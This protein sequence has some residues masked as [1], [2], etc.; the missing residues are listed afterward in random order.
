MDMKRF[1]L[2]FITIAALALA[3]C[4][5]NGG[6]GGIVGNG[7]GGTPLTCPGD[8]I[9]NPAMDM[10]VD[11][12]PVAARVANPLPDPDTAAPAVAKPNT[13]DNATAMFDGDLERN[14]PNAVDFDGG[15][16]PLVV[17][18][19]KVS[20]RTTAM[21]EFAMSTGTPPAELEGFGGSIHTRTIDA[22]DADAD[23]AV[24]ASD[25]MVDAVTV[26]TDQMAAT[27][28]PF[29]TI[30]PL[31]RDD[32]DAEAMGE[33]A[34]ELML[35]GKPRA[36]AALVR[37]TVGSLPQGTG[38]VVLM[39]DEDDTLPGMFDGAAGEYKCKSNGCSVSVDKD[40]KIGM[41]ADVNEF[42]FVPAMGAMVPVADDDYLSFGY[43]VQA[44]T[45][46][47][48]ETSYQVATFAT[49]KMPYNYN[50][51]IPDGQATYNGSATG[52]FV[53]K[54]DVDSDGMGV[55]PTSSGQFA[56]NVKLTATFGTPGTVGADFH[57]SISGK[58]T[59]FVDSNT[60]DMLAGW[61]LTLQKAALDGLGNGRPQFTGM[62]SGGEDMPI[63][64]WRGAFYGPATGPDGADTGE[65]P[66]AIMP[67]SVAGEFN[68]HFSDGH[69]LGA[70]GAHVAEE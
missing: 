27:L 4:G 44:T 69:A 16:R 38:M 26:Y 13:A 36:A 30:H 3:G 61:E 6:G 20:H 35:A 58:V 31:N 28:T 18:G 68:G 50:N 2:Y 10:C 51:A 65:E 56:A 23:L 59:N 5:G 64:G 25:M 33:D 54:T 40:G 14:S 57:D 19:N 60:G 34:T 47:E 45:D 22:V 32:E 15:N 70:F 42:N 29:A 48:G 24:V 39:V 55:V 52:V 17:D 1:F 12:E 63:G 66:D 21:P 7:N 37:F 49:G 8:Q 67:G 43:W 9:L 62:T 53:H 46:D 41:I 11:P